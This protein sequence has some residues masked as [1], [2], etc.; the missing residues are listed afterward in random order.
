MDWKMTRAVETVFYHHP[1]ATVKIHS[2]KLLEESYKPKVQ[3]FQSAGYNLVVVA[4]DLDALLRK[5]ATETGNSEIVDKFVQRKDSL[6]QND[7]YWYSNETNLLRYLL[8]YHYGGFYFD[9]DIYVQQ[10]IPSIVTNVVGLENK[11]V[12]NG[13]AMAFQ[14]NHEF[15]SASVKEFLITYEKKIGT[16]GAFG[17]FLISRLYKNNQ[18][19]KATVTLHPPKTFQPIPWPEVNQKCFQEVGYTVD[20][21]RTLAVHTNNKFSSK[22]NHTK[23][24]TFCD[25][26]YHKYLSSVL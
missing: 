22:Y 24:G 21:N 18:D 9:T 13:A 6:I 15:M 1:H 3:A 25:M 12:I 4:F 11:K 10:S 8:L 2:N 17:P 20:L 5:W 19:Y 14:K 16:W 26:V 7:V 23:E